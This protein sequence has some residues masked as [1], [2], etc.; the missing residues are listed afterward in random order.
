M[1]L[2]ETHEEDDVDAAGEDD[3]PS[4]T[5]HAPRRDPV[6][7]LSGYMKERQLQAV[8]GVEK[9]NIHRNSADCVQLT[10]KQTHQIYL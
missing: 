5:P 9:R 10:K 1:T 2:E 6:G 4:P 8:V 7:R 3:G